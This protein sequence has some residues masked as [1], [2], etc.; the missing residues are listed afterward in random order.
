[1]TLF[2]QEDTEKLKALAKQMEQRNNGTST[3]TDNAQ[4]AQLVVGDCDGPGSMI[5]MLLLSV[6]YI[7]IGGFKTYVLSGIRFHCGGH[8]TPI[9]E[10]Q[11][12]WCETC[13]V[14]SSG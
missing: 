1:M 12:V 6:M 11:S 3:A 8:L 10:K 14:I 13:R 7:S 9:S 2:L 4:I 5:L